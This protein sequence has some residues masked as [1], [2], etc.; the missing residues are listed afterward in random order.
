MPTVKMKTCPV[1]NRPN[2][3]TVLLGVFVF[4]RI[5]ANKAGARTI[6][7]LINENSFQSSYEIIFVRLKLDTKQR[8]R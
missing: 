8:P 6:G 1:N 7:T 4:D 2:L 3:I 5:K